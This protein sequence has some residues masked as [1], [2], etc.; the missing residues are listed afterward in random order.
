[1]NLWLKYGLKIAVALLIYALLAV[2]F[3][4][5]IH[6]FGMEMSRD[7]EMSGCLFIQEAAI[8]NMNTLEHIATLQA[9]FTS[10]PN[11]SNILFV[12][13]GLLLVVFVRTH[14]RPSDPDN[15]SY[16][17]KKYPLNFTSLSIYN[18]LQELFSRGILHPKLY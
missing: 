4:G 2:G 14:F 11:V 1:M 13:A 17:R 16:T 10:I 9:M 12:L 8:C 6:S 3:L 5:T 7:G 18:S 15:P